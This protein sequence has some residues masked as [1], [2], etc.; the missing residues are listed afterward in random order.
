MIRRRS[1]PLLVDDEP[2]DDDESES[3]DVASMT[4]S[5]LAAS[6]FV[7]LIAASMSMRQCPL[8]LRPLG[9]CHSPQWWR[10]GC[11]PSY[12]RV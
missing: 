4:I 12:Y 2:D 7:V 10:R 3:D 5:T 6:V 8:R 9:S 11:P 1:V